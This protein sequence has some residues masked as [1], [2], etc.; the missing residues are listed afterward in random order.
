[1]LD[2]HTEGQKTRFVLQT[3]RRRLLAREG[4]LRPYPGQQDHTPAA[5]PKDMKKACPFNRHKIVS[6]QPAAPCTDFPRT[7]ELAKRLDIRLCS[8]KQQLDCVCLRPLR[9]RGQQAGAGSV[10]PP[11]SSQRARTRHIFSGRPARS[12]PLSPGMPC[13]SL[14]RVSVLSQGGTPTWRFCCSIAVFFERRRERRAAIWFSKKFCTKGRKV[15]TPFYSISL[16]HTQ[17]NVGFH[18]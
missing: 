6:S 9:Q 17:V 11:D 8:G 2:L 14:A 16:L 12:A 1:M 18:I 7:A 10:W 5:A 3:E 4:R 13:P 15:H